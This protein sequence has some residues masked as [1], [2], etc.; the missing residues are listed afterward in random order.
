MLLYWQYIS[1]KGRKREGGNWSLAITSQMPYI[2]TLAVSTENFEKKQ[3]VWCKNI[4]RNNAR[5]LGSL[6]ASC[7][8]VKTKEGL[9]KS[10]YNW[11]HPEVTQGNHLPHQKRTL[12]PCVKSACFCAMLLLS[13]PC[14]LFLLELSSAIVNN[15]EVSQSWINI[16][17]IG[18]W[19]INL[20]PSFPSAGGGIHIDYVACGRWPKYS[21]W[22]YYVCWRTSRA[23]ST[24]QMVPSAALISILI[25]WLQCITIERSC[26]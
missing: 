14:R 10:L 12:N 7:F 20:G 6:L 26:H 2:F 1:H 23:A 3:K 13:S 25:A 19:W 5:Y 16:V 17:W 21:P 18:D 4:K 11:F 22:S 24:K 8:A 15:C 9:L